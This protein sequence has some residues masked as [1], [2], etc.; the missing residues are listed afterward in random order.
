MKNFI[1]GAVKYKIAD[2][3][4][5]LTELFN[6]LFITAVENTRRKTLTILGD[7]SN[8]QNDT[9]NVKKIVLEY[10]NHPGV[11]KI[12]EIFKDLGNFDLTKANPKD[13]NK[14]IKS[15]NSKKGTGLYKIPPK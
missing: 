13:I 7:Y 8:Q 1:F 10:E 6:T 11:V 4:V 12:K 2:N 3:G 14:I 5:K 9:D 15:L